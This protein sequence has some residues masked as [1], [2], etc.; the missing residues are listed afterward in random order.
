MNPY[1]PQDSQS[2]Y[3]AA[4]ANEELLLCGGL[5]SSDRKFD[6]NYVRPFFER[7]YSYS[8]WADIESSMFDNK[9]EMN[10]FTSMCLLREATELMVKNGTLEESERAAYLD[11]AL[12]FDVQQRYVLLRFVINNSG[13]I[14]EVMEEDGC[15]ELSLREYLWQKGINKQRPIGEIKTQTTLESNN[16][17]IYRFGYV[18]ALS[19]FVLIT[20]VL[21]RSL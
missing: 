8:E 1:Y 4:H 3:A 2:S 17:Q 19:A 5:S 7:A 6:L 18:I 20:V 16:K 12:D 10:C 9:I 21:L 13:I 14:S 11:V 15:G